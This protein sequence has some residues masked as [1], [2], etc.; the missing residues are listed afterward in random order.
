MTL[1][2]DLKRKRKGAVSVSDGITGKQS[3][4][5]LRV[6]MDISAKSERKKK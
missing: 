4:L 3:T 6:S 5:L 2:P 1:V